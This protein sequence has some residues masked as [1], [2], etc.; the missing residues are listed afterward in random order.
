MYLIVLYLDSISELYIMQH[1]SYVLVL[2][3][4]RYR[5]IAFVRVKMTAIIHVE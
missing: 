4:A 1:N 2:Y 3:N 5:V